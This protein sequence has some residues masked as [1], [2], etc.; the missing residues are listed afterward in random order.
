MQS[1][2]I[3]CMGIF[4]F[5]NPLQKM[6]KN[7]GYENIGV[8][9]FE[10]L[11]RGKN[12]ILIDVRTPFEIK[13]GKIDNA[14]ELDFMD[15]NFE[16]Q[17]SVLDKDATYLVYCRSGRRSARTCSVMNEMGFTSLYNLSGG[18]IAWSKSNS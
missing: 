14:L 4:S 10:E 7:K 18:Y 6:A 12:S 3:S 15:R 11:K 13:A 9:K 17:L 16:S 8:E 5:L 1:G 2:L